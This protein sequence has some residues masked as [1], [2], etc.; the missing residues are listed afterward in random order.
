MEEE[1]SQ[2]P[3]TS[4]SEHFAGLTDPRVEGRTDHPLVNIIVITVCAV[5]CGAESWVEV[6]L[7][8]HSKFDWLA[9]FLD[10][11]QGIPSHDTLGRVFGQL[12]AEQFQSCFLSWVQAAVEV[13]QGQVIAI[14][15]KTVRRSHNQ[16]I[17]K[18]A[19]HMVSAWASDNQLVLGQLKVDEKS[20]EITAIPALLEMLEIA[21]CIV[22]IDAMGCQKEIAQKIIDKEGDYALALKQNQGNLYQAVKELFEYAQE[23]AFVDCD[24]HQTIDKGHGR[25]EIR[26][27]WTIC[28]P[29]YLAYLPNWSAWAGLR[30]LGMVRSQR[31]I[32]GQE[33]TV[34]IRYYISSLAGLA[35]PFLNAV[36]GHWSIENQVHWVLDVAFREDDCRV[37][38]GNADQNFAVIRHIALNLLKQ[39]KT[40]K[41]GIKAKRLKAGWDEAYLLNVLAA[42]F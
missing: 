20:N 6:E 24:Y 39:E 25:I 10:L 16:A 14:D 32:I 21:G 2:A 36:R 13:T 18:A 33:P 15:G 28:Q 5:I 19:I 34:K 31:Q 9:Q 38:M 12:N 8:G 27:C 1:M 7:F 29:E 35:E 37:R 3:L 17:G 41:G 40:S 4:L 11:S 30:T 42:L 23:T 22:T 26:E